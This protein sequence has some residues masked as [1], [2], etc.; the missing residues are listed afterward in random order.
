MK[1]QGRIGRRRDE[2]KR[3]EKEEEDT[4]EEDGWRGGCLE[5][6]MTQEKDS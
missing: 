4:G 1:T 2:K 5:S 3:K 6:R